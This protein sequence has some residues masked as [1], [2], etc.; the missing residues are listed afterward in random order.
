[1]STQ[2]HLSGHTNTTP[3]L[4]SAEDID[5]ETL[6]ENATVAA[7]LVAGAFAGIAEHAVMFPVDSLKTRIQ[8][9]LMMGSAAAASPV[10]GVVSA[11]V[12]IVSQEG[13]YSLW[14]GSSSVIF[15]AGP[16]H[17]VYFG[18]YEMAK[19][20]LITDSRRHEHNPLQVGIAGAAATITSELFM[21][22]FDVIKQR[23]QLQTLAKSSFIH[24]TK[25]IYQQEGLK[26]FYL[27]YP[28][29]LAMTVP[30][31]VLQFTI[32]DSALKLL[33]PG[34]VYNPFMHCLAG[35]IAG[36]LAAAITNPLD[37]IKTLLQVRGESTDPRVMNADSM[38]RA[39][40]ALHAIDGW[41]G[42]WKGLRPRVVSNVPST[43]LCW[44][45]YEMAKY[46]MTRGDRLPRRLDT[47]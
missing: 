1:M 30:F 2:P 23:M 32:Y 16:A 42:F 46:Y 47:I 39:T 27:S 35:G 43:A 29:T 10:G 40:K 26:A 45:A 33:N 14:R 15:G 21:N 24:T 22:P 7:H 34:L 44:T 3:P 20:A 41:S 19:E 25:H 18:V 38:W 8:A 12:K 17:A 9:A 13:A 4:V 36:G 31:T 5:Y 28:T 37:C 6:P 11:C